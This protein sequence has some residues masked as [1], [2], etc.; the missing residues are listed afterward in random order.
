MYKKEKK[1]KERKAT[2]NK[3]W[4]KGRDS[5]EN[6]IVWLELDPFFEPDF[7]IFELFFKFFQSGTEGSHQNQRLGNNGMDLHETKAHFVK[8]TG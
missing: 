8:D 2:P 4:L 1:K 6:S 7:V 3:A 5:K